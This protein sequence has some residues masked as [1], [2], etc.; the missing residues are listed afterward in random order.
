M[1]APAYYSAKFLSKTVWKRKK[2]DPGVS[3]AP[4]LDPE[5]FSFVNLS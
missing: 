5:M 4:P 3:L 2:L 1:R